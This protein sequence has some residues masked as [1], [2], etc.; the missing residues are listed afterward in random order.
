MGTGGTGEWAWGIRAPSRR[1]VDDDV[2]RC[3]RVFV[4][5]Y[6]GLHVFTYSERDVHIQKYR[7]L[8]SFP[9]GDSFKTSRQISHLKLQVLVFRG[10]QSHAH[11]L[12]FFV[13]VVF[14]IL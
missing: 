5:V 2:G 11:V 14:S 12:I 13:V 7:V 3:K 4:S 10:S 9:R 6:V 8:T 1:D